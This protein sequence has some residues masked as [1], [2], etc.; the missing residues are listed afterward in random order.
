MPYSLMAHAN[1]PCSPLMTKLWI[2][3]AKNYDT[4]SSRVPTRQN[5]RVK[6]ILIMKIEKRNTHSK[7]QASDI[8]NRNCV[9]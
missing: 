3:R 6:F 2:R 8:F 7:D 1:I 9:M 5:T 4:T